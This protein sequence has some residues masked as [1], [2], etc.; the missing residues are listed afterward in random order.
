MKKQFKSALII[1]SGQITHSPDL[2]DFTDAEITA[3]IDEI[4][5]KLQ[6][7]DK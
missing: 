6:K 1:K 3:Q 5:F 4:F 7:K 2:Y